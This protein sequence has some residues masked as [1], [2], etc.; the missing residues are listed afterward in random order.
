[1]KVLLLAAS[2]VFPLIMIYIQ[3]RWEWIG[4][5]FNILMVISVIV[6]ADIAALSVYQIIIDNTVFMTA[7]HA[8][9]LDPVFLAAGAYA[10]TYTIYRLMLLTR[11]EW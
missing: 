8:V 1:M 3:Y 11:K 6:F 9:F 4:T 5:L 10:G 7:I 2:V